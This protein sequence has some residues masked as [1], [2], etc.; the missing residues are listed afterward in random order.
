M[1]FT[2]RNMNRTDVAALTEVIANNS[3]STTLVAPNKD[4]MGIVIS[5]PNNQSCWVKEQAASLD[6]DKKGYFVIAGGKF[7]MP[8]DNI[9]TGEISA[10]F[11]SGGSKT[12][13][14]V[15]K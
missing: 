11:N 14:I 10:I 13:Y 5:N 12:L 9:Y 8:K 1:K 15:E 3:T 7:I 6:N 4:R 2:G